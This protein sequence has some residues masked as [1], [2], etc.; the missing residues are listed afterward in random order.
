MKK[1]EFDIELM[2]ADQLQNCFDHLRLLMHDP[3]YSNQ[4]K[5]LETKKDKIQ[6]LLIEKYEIDVTYN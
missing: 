2:D 6:N 5:E 4:L 3:N 1:F